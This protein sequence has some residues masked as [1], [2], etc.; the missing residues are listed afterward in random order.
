MSPL[1]N[2][3]PLRSGP[4][5]GMRYRLDESGRDPAYAF[6]A[7]NLVLARVGSPG[8]YLRRLSDQLVNVTGAAAAGRAQHLGV[9]ERQAAGGFLTV[10]VVDGEV[11]TFTVSGGWTRVLTAAQIVAG[12]A[13]L[14]ATL[15][16]FA[17]TFT[18]QYVFTDNTNR[19]WMWDGTSGGGITVLTNAPAV[20]SG[21]PTVY[22]GKLFFIKATA[23]TDRSTIVW[24]EENL[25]NTG[26]EAGGYNNAW[27]LE[28]SS[29]G[30]LRAILGTNE[31]LYYWRTTS[32][33]LVR[34]AVTPDF[35]SAGVHDDLSV[36]IGTTLGRPL[37]YA[38]AVW[39]VDQ[40][41]RPWRFSS[42]GLQPLWEDLAQLWVAGG[43]LTTGVAN[44]DRSWGM[45]PYPSANAVLGRIGSG[46]GTNALFDAFTGRA[47]C[48]VSWHSSVFSTEAPG[49]V[50][51]DVNLR[52]S[53]GMLSSGNGAGLV[54]LLVLSPPSAFPL[55]S[56]VAT[57]DP[58]NYFVLVHLD[59]LP[60]GVLA[61]CRELEAVFIFEPKTIAGS[62][63]GTFIAS[64]GQSEVDG[65]GVAL[66]S[67]GAVTPP[68]QTFQPAEFR[69]QWGITTDVRWCPVKIESTAGWQRWGIANV[70]VRAQLAPTYPLKP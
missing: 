49:L 44:A 36:G 32:I 1:L 21:A 27:I 55:Y 26:Y 41:T 23:V 37:F 65:V 61:L 68:A 67:V 30:P 69:A 48:T 64:V 53:S 24:S 15:V 62:P 11:W 16:V 7:H 66:P 13:A 31:A 43:A 4:W 59:G 47:L 17:V 45:T 5:Q 28:Q 38:N 42:A 50:W 18:N 22:F 52:F 39:F 34:G 25:A 35:T 51:D 57:S 33:G 10:G 58:A 63:Q 2:E 19:P 12:G 40:E 60:P 29:H 9:F 6:L 8:P 70:L 46:G 14:S 20:T 56:D 3:W 54:P